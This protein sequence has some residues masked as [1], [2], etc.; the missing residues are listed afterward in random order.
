MLRK[1]FYSDT[2]YE[3]SI[4]R[5]KYGNESDEMISSILYFETLEECKRHV[6]KYKFEMNFAGADI[7]IN[8]L[9]R[10]V[11]QEEWKKGLYNIVRYK[12]VYEYLSDDEYDVK[13]EWHYLSSDATDANAASIIEM[14]NNAKLDNYKINYIKNI[15]YQS[16]AEIV[17]KKDRK[18]DNIKNQLLGALKGDP[19][20]FKNDS[21]VR[22]LLIEFDKKSNENKIIDVSNSLSVMASKL[23]KSD[24]GFICVELS[25]KSFG[26]GY[27]SVSPLNTGM[28]IMSKHKSTIW[29]YYPFRFLYLIPQLR[30]SG[31][32][33]KFVWFDR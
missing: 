5:F 6:E 1:D 21:R 23:I 33:I 27:T 3:L 9:D 8:V 22:L 24:C 25:G 12:K 19:P 11:I 32:K 18:R 2:V 31:L 10:K 17:T 16:P 29:L 13:E 4:Y 14:A 26:L 20:S 30:A 28:L 7:E 15:V